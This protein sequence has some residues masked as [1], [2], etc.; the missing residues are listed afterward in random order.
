MLAVKKTNLTMVEI[1]TLLVRHDTSYTTHGSNWI[2]VAS[3]RNQ[4]TNWTKQNSVLLHALGKL[5]LR[6]RVT[7]KKSKIWQHRWTNNLKFN[8]NFKLVAIIL[9][10][11][12]FLLLFYQYP[13]PL[14][15]TDCLNFPFR[16]SEYQ[17]KIVY[18]VAITDYSDCTCL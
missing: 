1:K 9:I 12:P 13:C 10:A 16:T 8:I 5:L 18:T 14:T 15:P 7:Q 6:C 3:L 11:C 17:N 4:C 2:D